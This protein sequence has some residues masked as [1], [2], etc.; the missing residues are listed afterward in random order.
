MRLGRAHTQVRPYI[1]GEDILSFYRRIGPIRRGGKTFSHFIAGSYPFAV[2]AHLCVRPLPIANRAVWSARCVWRTANGR[3][4]GWGWRW[5][6]R[7]AVGAM[8]LGRAHTQVR[9]YNVGVRHSFILS[10]DRTNSPWGEDILSFYRGIAPI[11]RGGKAFSHFIAGSYPFAV[12]AH[13][14]VRP[15]PIANRAV[16]SARCVWG[17]HSLILSQDRTHS[18]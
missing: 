15:L 1:V 6:A 17:G 4:Y 9:P 14:C 10:Q 11:R 2:G 8:R 12:G 18:P 13:L 16:R 5:C 7:V 3:P